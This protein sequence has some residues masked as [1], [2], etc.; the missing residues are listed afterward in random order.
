[1]SQEEL[2]HTESVDRVL[3]AIRQVPPPPVSMRGVVWKAIR[4]PASDALRLGAIGLLGPTLR[5]RFGVTW[6]R[7][8]QARFRMLSRASRGLTPVLPEALKVTGPAQLRWR[9]EAI[10]RGPLGDEC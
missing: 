8:D 2:V 4:I 7:A 10:A 5:A 3:R 9:Q 1:M 6:S